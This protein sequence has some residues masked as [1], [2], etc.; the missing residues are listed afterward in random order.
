MKRGVYCT[1]HRAWGSGSCRACARRAW[2]RDLVLG[3]LLVNGILWGTWAL[4][5]L[6]P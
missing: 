3:V 6:L 2:V 5:N 4:V 1:R